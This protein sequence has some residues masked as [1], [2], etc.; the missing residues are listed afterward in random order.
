M[1]DMGREML[2]CQLKVGAASMQKWHWILIININQD[3]IF[4]FSIQ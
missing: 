2:T 3:Q 4:Q 1:T